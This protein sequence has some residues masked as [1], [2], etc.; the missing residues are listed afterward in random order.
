MLSDSENVYLVQANWKTKGRF[1]LKY[2]KDIN[3]QD[4]TSGHQQ[5]KDSLNLQKLLRNRQSIKRLAQLHKSRDKST[6]GDQQLP[7][8]G[9]G[10]ALYGQRGD[11]CASPQRHAHSEGEMGS[12]DESRTDSTNSTAFHKLTKKLSF[13]K[14]NV[15]GS[16]TSP[17]RG[18]DTRLYRDG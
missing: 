9:F 11:T 6:T 3:G 8:G 10:Q 2:R 1:E 12:D 18:L 17:Q 5:I 15:F 4:M 13:K 16:K 14:L 7:S